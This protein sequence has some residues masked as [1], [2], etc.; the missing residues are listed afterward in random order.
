MGLKL[1]G[2]GLGRTGTL[3][4]KLALE[5]LGLGPCYHMTEIF[6]NPSHAPLWLRAAENR[7]DW[8]G[9]FG[10]YL[11]S[12]DYPGCTFWRELAEFYPDAKVLLSVRDA[13]AWFEST[14]ATI[15]SAAQLERSR[16]GPLQEFFDSTVLRDLGE[17]IHDRDFM[18]DHFMRHNAAVERAIPRERLLVYETAQGWEPLC[19]FLGMATPERAFPRANTREQFAQRRVA[20]DHEGQEVADPAS[21]MREHLA[22]LREES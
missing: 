19:R 13:N 18:I 6:M 3:S 22:R 8:E 17:H 10:G 15:F 21:F 16:S 7:A 5:Q 14:Q 1:I 2:A 11:S 20:M 12:V 9:L 4:I